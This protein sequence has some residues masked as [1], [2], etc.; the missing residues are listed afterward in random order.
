MKPIFTWELDRSTGDKEQQP[1]MPHF[2]RLFMIEGYAKL[3]SL[4]SFSLL[5]YFCI[6]TVAEPV[7]FLPTL[8]LNG[9]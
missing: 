5:F 7:R 1:E 2:C 6:S 3:H 4:K 9:E 8:G